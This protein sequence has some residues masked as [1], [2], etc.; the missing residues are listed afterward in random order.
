MVIAR[1]GTLD[2]TRPTKSGTKSCTHVRVEVHLFSSRHVITWTPTV[3]KTIVRW[4]R[5]EG[6]RSVIILQT[7][8]SDITL[9]H[10]W[11]ACYASV[12]RRPRYSLSGDADSD[13]NAWHGFR[14]HG[15]SGQD[16]GRHGYL[17]VL[18]FI[19]GALCW[20]LG[21]SFQEPF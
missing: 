4:A 21:E 7:F 12:S 15:K 9:L 5:F 2:Q 3:C 16:G 10:T 11:L 19:L 20:G 8:R 14:I 6:F 18:F 13:S 1:N 17:Q